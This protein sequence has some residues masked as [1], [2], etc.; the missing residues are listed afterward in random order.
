[1][2][3]GR[4]LPPSSSPMEPCRPGDLTSCFQE[5]HTAFLIVNSSPLPTPL[6]S[7]DGGLFFV[8]DLRDAG[9]RLPVRADVRLAQDVGLY[10][11][12][13]DE[14]RRGDGQYSPHY[15]PH[16]PEAQEVAPGYRIL[17]QLGQLGAPSRRSSSSA[18]TCQTRSAVG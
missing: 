15:R 14:R 3:S 17:L 4:R 1:M 16:D 13:E 12:V 2:K 5:S 6:S 9:D 7:A 8:R 10:Y 11:G 18:L